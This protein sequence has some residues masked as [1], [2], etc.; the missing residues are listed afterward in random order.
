[1]MIA[2]VGRALAAISIGASLGA[3]LR[4]LLGLGLNALFPPILIGTLTANLI[5]GYC[6]GLALAAFIAFP[7]LGPEWRLLIVTGFLGSLTTFS[8][9][10]GETMLLLTHHRFFTATATILL[11]VAGSLGMTFLGMTTFPFLRN[12]FS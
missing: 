7:S 1:M 8:A 9:F 3:T 11:H 10:S 12:L 4:W 6:M 5:G 2:D